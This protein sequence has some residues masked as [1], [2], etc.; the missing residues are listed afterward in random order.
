MLS[1]A[2]RAG[3]EQ[4]LPLGPRLE[5]VDVELAVIDGGIVVHHQA[6]AV[7]P[8][9]ADGDLQ[10]PHQ[11]FLAVGAQDRPEPSAAAATAAAA[12]TG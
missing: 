1:G 2:E 9:V 10:R 12:A 11:H 8:A 6:A 3:H 7:V 4:E 5:A